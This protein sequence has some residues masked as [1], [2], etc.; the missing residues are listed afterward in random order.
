MSDIYWAIVIVGLFLLSVVVVPLIAHA[1][2][3][4]KKRKVKK[5]PDQWY[6]TESN[7]GDTGH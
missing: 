3:T 2:K 4:E 6:L 5:Q 7:G 1:S